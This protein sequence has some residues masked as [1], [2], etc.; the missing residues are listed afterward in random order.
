[1]IL[2]GEAGVAWQR[3]DAGADGLADE[4]GGFSLERFRT[5][6][7]RRDQLPLTGPRCVCE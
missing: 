1:M 6:G 4:G 2:S 3:A 5:E 7:A